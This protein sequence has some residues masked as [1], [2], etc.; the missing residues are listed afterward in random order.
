[1]FR[2]ADAEVLWPTFRRTALARARRHFV[3]AM[4]TVSERPRR[5]GALRRS[6]TRQSGLPGRV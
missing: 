2:A 5:I 1:V 4:E 3:S 6:G